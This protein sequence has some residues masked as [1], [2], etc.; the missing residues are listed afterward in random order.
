[1]KKTVT[2]ATLM[3]LFSAT[4]AAK[5]LVYCAEG[6]PENFNPQLYTSGTSVDA[7]AV[8]IFNRLVEFKTGTTELEPSLAQR[9]EISPDGTVYTFY[10]REGVQFHRSK[11]FTPTRPLNADDVIFS[12]MRQ[13]DPNNPY[14]KVSGGTYANF[15]S[16]EFGKLIKKIEKVDEHTVRFTLAHAEAPFLADLAWY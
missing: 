7:S 2:C 15:E 14:H 8:P 6:S 16:L 3:L 4:A 13:M 11:D 12:F 9:W 5:T 10:L 1:M